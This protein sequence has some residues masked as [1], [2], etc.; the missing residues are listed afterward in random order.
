M[1]RFLWLASRDLKA[2]DLAATLGVMRAD[3]VMMLRLMHTY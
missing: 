2:L 1:A 3:A